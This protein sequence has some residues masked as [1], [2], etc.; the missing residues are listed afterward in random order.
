MAWGAF[1]LPGMWAR[2]IARA[3]YYI[4]A[5]LYETGRSVALDARDLVTE[6]DV[7]PERT[8]RVVRNIGEGFA[9]DFRH[10]IRNLPFLALDVL[11]LA[12]GG[13]TTGVRAAAAL[14]TVRAAG[15]GREVVEALARL[16][17]PGK[18]EFKARYERKQRTVHGAQPQ[19][20]FGQKGY[21]D[22]VAARTM[23]EVFDRRRGRTLTPEEAG[24]LSE[25]DF[26]DVQG[27]YSRSPLKRS[28]QKARDRIQEIDPS[29]ASPRFKLP[30]G[31]P[32]VGGMTVLAPMP[33]RRSNEQMRQLYAGEADRIMKRIDLVERAERG[34]P[35]EPETRSVAAQT[36]DVANQA[37]T[38]GIL[39]LKP[40]YLMPNLIGQ[41]ALTL[42]HQHFNP[43]EL[44]RS[45]KM[46][47][48]ITG[49]QLGERLRSGGK[50]E[51]DPLA[52]RV[53][54]VTGDQGIVR[55]LA[56]EK[57]GATALTRGVGG[58][59]EGLSNFYGK[60]LDTPF[61]SAAF[62]YEARRKGYRSR[63]DIEGLFDGNHNDDLSEIATKANR[64]MIDY[65]NLS[66]TERNLIRRVVFFYPWVKGATVYGGHFVGEH[67]MQAAS[68]AAIGR[69]GQEKAL[70]DLGELPSYAQ[71][72][73]K[74]GEREIPGIGTVPLVSNPAAA[75]ILGTPAD[76]L[77]AVRGI[78]EGNV[79]SGTGLLSEYLNPAATAALAAVTRVD[80]FT[81]APID[82]GKSGLR[83]LGE[84]F[85]GAGEQSGDL[86]DTL[87]GGL[88]AM[89]FIR[90][91][92]SPDTPVLGKERPD[93]EALRDRL[94]PTS[95]PSDAARQFSF[96]TMGARP[97]NVPVAHSRARAEARELMDDP[98]RVLSRFQDAREQVL[99]ELKRVGIVQGDMLPDELEQA[100]RMRSRREY[101]KAQTQQ[102]LGRD[103][104]AIDRLRS[105]L[106]L[107]SRMKALS[108]RD[109]RQLLNNME[110]M[111]DAQIDGYRSQLSRLFFQGATLTQYRRM[112]RERQGDETVLS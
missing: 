87:V 45:F 35:P 38:L 97:L 83:V 16:P 22:A 69:M 82:P 42:T 6:G 66:K 49:S 55:S 74:V 102:R 65:T 99:A 37:A 57:V 78:A 86:L 107:L 75:S 29:H 51:Y 20:Q 108:P 36:V 110:G 92:V 64:A 33:V 71:G 94:Y 103:L 9:E 32:V 56:P 12:S 80:P 62:F 17:E 15:S 89:R 47:R 41:T 90:E 60:I 67:P 105:D 81:Q 46:H 95:G 14:R 31:L 8:G 91:S 77:E 48:E 101:A 21:Y 2:D 79:R 54:A 58:V 18:R 39:Y 70:E 43:V 30:P 96:G 7:T 59:H 53:G 25:R 26:G 44:M 10:P 106:E 3:A 112:L 63:E 52:A 109:I 34:D 50:K 76:T 84:Q 98:Q 1:S 24:E 40:S 73:F 68:Q 104:T 88:P 72:V 93:T 5:G 19:R 100:L 23:V 4:P 13:A 61:R 28:A 11:G 111:S 85:L 27:F